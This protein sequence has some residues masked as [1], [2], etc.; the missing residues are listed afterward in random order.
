MNVEA[1]ATCDA[2]ATR[3]LFGSS[4]ALGEAR[5]LQSLALMPRKQRFKPSRKPQNQASAT[6]VQ[7]EQRKADHPENQIDQSAP[8]RETA[9]EIDRGRD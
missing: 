7:G 1:H 3:V 9:P 6:P 8:E 5:A 2:R 4:V